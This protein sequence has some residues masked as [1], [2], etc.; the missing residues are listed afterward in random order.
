ME[1]YGA[2]SGL[3]ERLEAYCKE[4][5]AIKR[6]LGNGVPE[7][8]KGRIAFRLKDI[9]QRLVPQLISRIQLS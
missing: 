7:G 8:K 2:E 3:A 6:K 9:E 4:A 1:V 5:G